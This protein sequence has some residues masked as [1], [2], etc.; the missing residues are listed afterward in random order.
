MK[1]QEEKQYLT[2]KYIKEIEESDLD[3]DT[4]EKILG[5]DAYEEPGF[6]RIF[7]PLNVEYGYEQEADRISIT[8]LEKTIA[9]MKKAGASHLEMMHHSDHRGYVFYG[10]EVRRSTKA[11]VDDLK[12]KNLAKEEIER[13]LEELDKEKANLIKSYRKI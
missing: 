9:K 5:K 3:I 2:F 8:L 13:R 7:I 12:I 1:K 11:E 4:V 10:V 6:E